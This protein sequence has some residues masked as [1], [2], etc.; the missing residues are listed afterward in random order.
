MAELLVD[1]S[2]RVV[3]VSHGKDAADD[4]L[5][6]LARGVR[7]F[8][9]IRTLVLA[10]GD[11]GPAFAKIIDMFVSGQPKRV[12]VV[13][14]DCASK[15][16]S[17]RG[18]SF[19]RIDQGILMAE[20]ARQNGKILGRVNIPPPSPTDLIRQS[21]SKFAKNPQD[22]SIDPRHNSWIRDTIAIWR[23]TFGANGI[24]PINFVKIREAVEDKFS[25]ACS[26]NGNAD[27]SVPDNLIPTG[28]EIDALAKYLSDFT[29]I[30]ERR[31]MLFFNPQSQY[32]SI[33]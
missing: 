17:W 12:E 14:Y 25:F 21:V 15:F 4:G 33:T 27:E 13:A 11:A 10:T 3:L 2:Y 31:P 8:K 5:L 22:G 28:E 7:N 26:G 32:N 20:D 24:H 1:L 9:N 6:L 30:F 16:K 29:D 23:K 19:S 18:V